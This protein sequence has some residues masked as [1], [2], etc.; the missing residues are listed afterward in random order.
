MSLHHI[1]WRATASGLADE[2]VVADALAWLMDDEEA[3]EIERTTSYH[4]SEI[5]IVEAKTT[6]KRPALRCLARLGRKNL[7][8]LLNEVEARLDESHTLH[9]RLDFNALINGEV[10][11]ASSD[12]GPTIKGHTKVQVFPGQE[13]LS[14]AQST[15]EAAMALA[16]AEQ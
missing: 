2:T 8:I 3:V 14:E 4:G 15:I 16:D 7:Q 1:T 10:C 12:E 6:R 11:L 5:H 13:G 9:I